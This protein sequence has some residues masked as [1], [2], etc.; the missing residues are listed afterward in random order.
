[1]HRINNTQVE[2]CWKNYFWKSQFILL[3]PHKDL[4][5][6]TR[7]TL[8]AEVTAYSNICVLYIKTFSWCVKRLDLVVLD[9]NFHVVVCNGTLK[10]FN[11]CPFR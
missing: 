6:T 2:I 4:L 9:M 8:Y 3:L 1:M 11:T 5:K 7:A 10:F